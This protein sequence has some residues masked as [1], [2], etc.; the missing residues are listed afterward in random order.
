M[1][2]FFTCS[3]MQINKTDTM[4]FT[5]LISQLEVKTNLYSYGYLRQN[6]QSVS[7]AA[8]A[9]I[10]LFRINSMKTNQHQLKKMHLIILKRMFQY[11]M[12]MITKLYRLY[13]AKE[14]LFKIVSIRFCKI[15]TESLHSNQ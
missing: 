1:A 4:D 6:T 9:L 12:K 10:A 15:M 13:N 3:L 14:T 5:I 7:L 11:L 2:S 8:S